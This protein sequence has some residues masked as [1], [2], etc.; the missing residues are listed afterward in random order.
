[1]YG[2]ILSEPGATVSLS[3]RDLAERSC[4]LIVQ[5]F[6]AKVTSAHNNVSKGDGETDV[7][8]KKTRV[9]NHIRHPRLLHEACVLVL[10]RGKPD[11][12]RDLFGLR[13]FGL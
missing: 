7:A 4:K 3:N 1:M 8:L 5:V 9:T 10:V 12:H 13:S 6:T 2:K 11:L